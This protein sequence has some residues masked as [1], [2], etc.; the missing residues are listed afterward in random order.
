VAKELG[1]NYSSAKTII[2]TFRNKKRVAKLNK[3]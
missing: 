1:L 2:N 3:K